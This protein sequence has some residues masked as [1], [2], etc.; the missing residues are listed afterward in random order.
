[1]GRVGNRPGFNRRNF[2]RGVGTVAVGLPFLEGLPERSAWAAGNAPVFSFF[3]V[4][5][6]GVVFKSFFPAATGALTTA[7]LKAGGDGSAS[8][9]IATSALAAHAPNLLF[10]KG[11]NY[12]QPGP[13]ACGHAE[14]LTQTLTGIKP[15]MTGNKGYSG[16]PSADTVIAKAVNGGADP[17]ALYSGTKGF[18]AER[19]SFKAAGAGNVRAA[20]VNPYLLYSRVIGLASAAPAGGGGTTTTPTVDP[21][22]AE[23]ATTRKSVNDLVRAELKSLQSNSALSAA[24][25][26][27]LQQ[28]FDAIRDVEVKM[29]QMASGAVCSTGGITTSAYDAL[30]S[31]FAFNGANMEQI[32]KLH[33]QIVAIA[34]GCGYS[35]TGTLQWGD[36]TDGTKYNVP[37]N[38]TLGMWP[39]HQISHRIQ[40]DS[41]SGNNP[42]AE[43]AHHEIDTLRMSTL[44]AG[45]DVFA[46]HGLQDKSAIVWTNSIADGPSHSTKNVPMIIWGSGGGY[47]KQGTYIDAAS[48]QNDAVLNTIITAAT[49]DAASP[50]TMLGGGSTLAAMKA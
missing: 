8:S 41:A 50:A 30:K 6:N 21:V 46:A 15:G 45:L 49:R 27:R 14:G 12:Q 33:L 38:V 2:L 4:A 35:R 9:M 47:L 39:F 7:S 10:I 34:F 24:D 5:E 20:D 19:I 13:Q 29:T 37:T 48:S 22:A 32:V 11:I 28:H 3:I 25:Q 44:A 31:G 17:L 40:S 43:Q 16:G 23:L 42:T 18:I 26:T 36:G 1:M